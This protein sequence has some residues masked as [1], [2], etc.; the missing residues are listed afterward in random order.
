MVWKIQTKQNF[1]IVPWT[2][3]FG[4]IANTWWVL[5]IV[6]NQDSLWTFNGFNESRYNN[7]EKLDFLGIIVNNITIMNITRKKSRLTNK[8]RKIAT[9]FKK[10]NHLIS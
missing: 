3:M 6:W 1:T 8:N 7:N 5:W 9:R 4:I 2:V 10:I